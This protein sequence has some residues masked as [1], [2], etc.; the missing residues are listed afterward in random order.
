VSVIIFRGK[1]HNKR[2]V[3]SLLSKESVFVAKIKAAWDFKDGDPDN[4][5]LKNSPAWHAYQEEF[6]KIY[7]DGFYAEQENKN[8]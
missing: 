3:N 6:F 8:D 5:Y 2:I 1:H 4:T 7:M